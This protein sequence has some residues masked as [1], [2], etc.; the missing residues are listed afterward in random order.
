ML[1]FPRA[2]SLCAANE[3]LSELLAG[4]QQ[5][6]HLLQNWNQFPLSLNIHNAEIHTGLEPRTPFRDDEEEKP[7]T[8]VC[9]IFS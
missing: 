6:A 1:K 3:E 8:K 7:L 5:K 4:S 2:N 9:C